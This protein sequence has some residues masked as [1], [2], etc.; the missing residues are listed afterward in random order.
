MTIA[1]AFW[2]DAPGRGSIHSEPLDAPKPGEVRVRTTASGLSVGTERLVFA[3][4]VPPSEHERMRA[5]LQAGSFPAPVKYGYAAVGIV[6]AGEPLLQGCRVFCLHPHQDR[7]VAPTAMAVPIPDGVPDHRA[8]LAAN[9]ETALNA[10]WDAAPVPGERTAVV[11]QGV[12]GLLTAYLLARHGHAP[13]VIEPDP[14]RAAVAR[15]L[16]LTVGDAALAG[17]FDLIVHASGNPEGLVWSLERLAFEG[18]VVELSWYG[19]RAV[20]LPLGAA[21]HSRRL[22]ILSSQVGV[23]APA[24]RDR[25]T[26]ARRLAMA[27]ALLD[28]PRLDALVDATIPLG[29]L[30]VFMIELAAGRRR[31]LCARITYGDEDR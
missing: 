31:V 15:G 29:A 26:H 8:V 21:F 3:G 19:D 23:V 27:L 30:P 14:V 24:M 28:E 1:R 10:L 7:F 13:V 11:G 4:S 6:E 16:G 20:T 18:R 5:P 22:K 9:M 17:P 2:V 12:V 25:M